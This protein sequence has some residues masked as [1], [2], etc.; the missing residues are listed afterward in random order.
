M[1][2]IY[3]I[4]LSISLVVVNGC[5][6]FLEEDL[7]GKYSNSTFYKT[8]A[9]ALL[10]LTAI[11]NNVAF[12]NTDNCLWVFGDV[13]SDDAV[14]GGSP[15][16]Q[17]DIQ[18]L[19]EFNY[20]RNNGFLEKYWKHYYEGISRANY[21]LYY[22]P[23]I[24]M[25]EN[26]KSRILGEAKFLRA[27]QYFILVNTFGEIPLKTNPP[28]N[29]DEINKP[30]SSVS[31][32]YDQ[33]EKD[34][35]EAASVLSVSYTGSDVG[36]ATKGAAYGLLAKAH[37]YQEEWDQTLSAI[38]SLE[39]LGI[40]SLVPVYKNNFIDSTQNNGESI[41]EI[42]HLSGQSPKL[43]SHLNQW[44]GP[45]KYN[46]YG[47]DAPL[48]DFVDEFETT[49]GSVVDPR[50]DYT[51]GRA[52]QPWID[53]TPFDPN[54]SSTGFLQRKH[55]QPKNEEPVIGDASLNYVYMRYADILLMKA[56]ALNESGNTAA[57]L[58]PLNAVRKRARESYLNDVDLPGYGVVPDGLL[59][60][61]TGT[62][63]DVRDAIRHERRVEL[64]F[65]FHRFFDLMRYGKAYAEDAL[66]DT[67]FSYDENRYFLIPQSELDTNPSI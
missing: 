42:Q 23:D 44:L 11:Y 67:G 19:D 62:Q 59:P 26:L 24:V 12:V 7:I 15:G 4:L 20:S 53:G 30:V 46:G 27:Y 47:F 21:L 54:Q 38:E 9:H 66:K 50:L 17:N 6:D 32:I 16:D 52:G 60:D 65:E 8:E 49:D 33:I 2:N 39:S 5:S 51:V 41:F 57:A 22:G 18:F 56:E 34:L 14:K 35:E 45:F 58:E 1:K 63:S 25:D 48:Q 43:G 31:A 3:T 55:E 10:A 28:L 64:G 40:Y 37:L 29:S 61:V 13:V 36:R